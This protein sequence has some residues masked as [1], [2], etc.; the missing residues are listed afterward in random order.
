MPAPAHVHLLPSAFQEGRGLRPE[1]AGVELL[2]ASVSGAGVPSASTAAGAGQGA[3]RATLSSV[4]PPAC[5]RPSRFPITGN[6]PGFLFQPRCYARFLGP[7]PAGAG[8]GPGSLRLRMGLEGLWECSWVHWPVK[9][10]GH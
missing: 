4:G 6:P 2:F 8:C 1:W 10:R 3:G 7:E 9:G 5:S